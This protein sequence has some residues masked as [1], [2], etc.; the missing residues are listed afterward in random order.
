MGLP[1]LKLTAG[2]LKLFQKILLES[3]RIKVQKIAAAFKMHN[4]RVSDG[5]RQGIAENG[6]HEEVHDAARDD[7]RDHHEGG[8][9][10]VS[11]AGRDHGAHKRHDR[12]LDSVLTLVLSERIGNPPHHRYL[13]GKN[14]CEIQNVSWQQS[15][16][17]GDLSVKL[18]NVNC[19]IDGLGR[20]KNYSLLFGLRIGFAVQAPAQRAENLAWATGLLRCVER[21]SLFESF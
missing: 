4:K 10:A 12:A 1:G 5:L 7:G 21:F 19:L 9:D 11:D 13:Y 18:N 3:L 6:G 20:S 14:R 2:F 15:D 8:R 16:H 17:R